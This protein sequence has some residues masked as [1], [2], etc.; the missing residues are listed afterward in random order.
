MLNRIIFTD[1]LIHE[2]GYCLLR[3]VP[4][5]P[6]LIPA[7]H[8]LSE[9]VLALHQQLMARSQQSDWPLKHDGITFRV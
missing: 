8:A 6:G 9:E 1:I 7:P 5:R 3:G 2:E 4:N